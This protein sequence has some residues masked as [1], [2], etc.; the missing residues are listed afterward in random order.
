MSVCCDDCLLWWLSAMTMIVCD[1][2]VCYDYD[3]LLYDCLLYNCLLWSPMMS[4]C[5]MMMIVCYDDCPLWRLTSVWNDDCLHDMMMIVCY[6]IVRRPL[7]NCCFDECL[8]S[9]LWWL[10]AMTCVWYDNSAMMMTVCY[11]CL[12]YNC[13]LYNC[14]LWRLSAMMIVCYDDCLHV[15]LLVVFRLQAL[16]LLS[17]KTSEQSRPADPTNERRDLWHHSPLVG[18]GLCKRPNSLSYSV[19]LFKYL[20]K[21]CLD[22]S[23]IRL[24]GVLYFVFI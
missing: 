1:M 13:L 22:S 24:L 8:L 6:M 5:Y 17:P 2:I 23:D 3:C 21:L 20:P 7:F 4:V 16:C 15:S 11:D 14:L 12:L 19:L 10:S 18:R 9:L